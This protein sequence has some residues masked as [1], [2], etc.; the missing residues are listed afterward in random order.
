MFQARWWPWHL[1]CA[2]ILGGLV[3]LGY[4]Q[5]GVAFNPGEWHGEQFSIRNFVYALQWWVFGVFVIWFWFRYMRDQRDAELAVASEEQAI[6]RARNMA[7]G[8]GP[9]GSDSNG[10]AAGAQADDAPISLDS[11]AAERRK[12]IFGERASGPVGDVDDNGD[13]EQEGQTGSGEDSDGATGSVSS[14]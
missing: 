4:W 14:S 6:G 13:Q 1:I 2:C 3:F 7:G 12:Q 5:M 10:D 8:T 11:P 9:S